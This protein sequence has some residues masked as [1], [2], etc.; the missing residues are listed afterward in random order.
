MKLE[1]LEAQINSN[2]ED[3][4]LWDEAEQAAIDGQEHEAMAALYAN[5][6]RQSIAP[7]AADE[8]GQRAVGWYE[9]WLGETAPGLAEVL[10]R[11]IHLDPENPWAFQKLTVI[12]TA[13]GRWE[14]LLAAYDS[15]IEVAASEARRREL[16]DE[17]YA[18]A[19]DLAHDAA[20]TS[21][22]LTKLLELDPKDENLAGSLERLLIKHD[23]HTGLVKHLRSRLPH[24]SKADGHATRLRMATTLYEKLGDADGAVGE[25]ETLFADGVQPEGSLELLEQIASNEQ[26][27]ESSR[28][29]AY[30][31]LE[32]RYRLAGRSDDLV[33][34]LNAALMLGGGEDPRLHRAAGEKMLEAGEAAG[35]FKHF[36]SVLESLPNDR[37]ARETLRKLVDETGDHDAYVDVLERA[38]TKAAE[39]D[40]DHQTQVSLLEEAAQVAYETNRD[41]ARRRTLLDSAFLVAQDDAQKLSVARE[42]ADTLGQLSEDEDEASIAQW[43]A[44]HGETPSER[45]RARVRSAQLFGKLERYDDAI[46]LWQSQLE[47]EPGDAESQRGLIEV[48]TRAERFEDLATYLRGRAQGEDTAQAQTDLERAAA[49]LSEQVGDA[50]QALTVWDEVERRFGASDRSVTARVELLERVERWEDAAGA[51][52]GEVERQSSALSRALIHAGR[53]KRDQLSRGVEAAQM[54]AR[55]LAFEPTN[56]PAREGLLALTE[57]EDAA[58]V[59][60]AGLA[61]AYRDAGE[62]HAVLNLLEPRLARAQSAQERTDLYREAFALRNEAGESEAA[63][64]DLIE[65]VRHSPDDEALSIQMLARARDNGLAEEAYAL[66]TELTSVVESDA[67][68]QNLHRMAFDLATRDLSRADAILHHGQIVFLEEPSSISVTEEVLRAA[69]SAEQWQLFGIVFANHLGTQPVL[70]GSFVSLVESLIGIDESPNVEAL[71]AIVDALEEQELAAAVARDLALTMGRWWIAADNVAQADA[72]YVRALEVDARS[73]E[74]IENLVSLRRPQGG[75]P[76]FEALGAA[77]A[78]DESNLDPGYEAA[79]IAL[80]L[81]DPARSVESLQ[82]VLDAASALVRQR[83]SARGERSAEGVCA[84]AIDTLAALCIREGDT[85][86]AL[87]VLESGSTM[88]MDERKRWMREAADLALKLGNRDRAT[89]LYRGV[90][91]IDED[92]EAMAALAALCEEDGRFVEM[93]GLR[94]RALAAAADLDERIRLRL[95]VARVVAEIEQRGGRIDALRDNLSEVPGHRESIEELTRVLESHGQWDALVDDLRVQARH[96]AQQGDVEFAATLWNKVA[97]VQQHHR[98]DTEAACDAFRNAVELV[99][100]P[101]SLEALA[102]LRTAQGEHA[103]AAQWLERR[104]SAAAEDERSEVIYKLAHAY[105][106]AGHRERAVLHL[107][108]GSELNPADRSI[109]DIL[110]ELYEEDNNRLGLAELWARSAVFLEK[111]DAM[112]AR[113]REAAETYSELGIPERAVSVLEQ[114]RTAA[115]DDQRIQLLYADALRGAERHEESI[116]VLTELAESFGRRRTPERADVH[117]RLGRVYREAG[118]LEEAIEQ[119]GKASSIDMKNPIYQMELGEVAVQ[120]RT[121]DK[122]ERAYRS[123]LLHVRRMDAP[124]KELG[125]GLADVQYEMSGLAEAQGDE[126][127]A[128]ELWRSALE[129]AQQR[130]DETATLIR[131]LIVSEQ[132]KRALEVAEA[133]LKEAENETQ[134]VELRGDIL[135]A[136]G[137]T[138]GALEAYCAA[139]VTSDM[140]NTELFDKARELASEHGQGELYL[141]SLESKF[142]KGGLTRAHK[143]TLLT[144]IARVQEEDLGRLED[145]TNTLRQI[146][147]LGVDPVAALQGQARIAARQGDT[148]TQGVILETIARGGSEIP[149]HHRADALL[150]LGEIKLNDEAERAQGTQFLEEALRLEPRYTDAAQ[151]LRKVEISMHPPAMDL[152]SQVVRSSTDSDL[153]L[154]F[155]AK[156]AR[157]RSATVDD[158]REAYA[159]AQRQ[160][161]AE[162]GREMLHRALEVAEENLD[163]TQGLWAAEA[164]SDELLEEGKPQEAFEILRKVA[165]AAGG[166]EGVRLWRKAAERAHQAGEVETAAEVYNSL[167]TA[168]PTHDEVWPSYLE[169]LAETNNEEAFASARQALKDEIFDGERRDFID[170]Q[171][172]KF[173]L[174]SDGRESEAATVLREILGNQPDHPEASSLLADVFERTGF[175]ED[176]VELLREQYDKAVAAQEADRIAEVG[177]RLGET[178]ARVD[179]EA[180][181]EVYRDASEKVPSDRALAEALLESLGDG[182]EVRERAIVEGRLLS[183]DEPE[184]VGTRALD[185]A[186][187]WEELGEPE[188]IVEVLEAAYERNPEQAK[189]REALEEAYHDASRWS[190]LASFL[191]REAARLDDPLE[192][193]ALLRRAATIRW[194]H[195][196]QA[197]AAAELLSR[198]I[199][200]SPEDPGGVE[201]AARMWFA[202]GKPQEVI[203]AVERSRP[204]VQD[205]DRWRLELLRA[206]ALQFD[207]RLDESVSAYRTAF[208]DAPTE[209]FESYQSA[210]QAL[211]QDARTEQDATRERRAIHEMVEVGRKLGQPDHAYD[212]LSEWHQSNMDDRESL[213]LLIE[214]DRET[215]NAQALISHSGLRVQMTEGEQQVEAALA[216]AEAAEQSQM[217]DQVVPVLESVAEEHPGDASIRQRL[218]SLYES[219]GAYSK[220]AGLLMADVENASDEDL[221]HELLKQAGRFYT[222]AGEAEAG[223]VP[224]QQAFEL[225][226]ED[227]ETVVALVDGYIGNN[228]IAEAGQTLEAAIAAHTRKRG[229]QLA[230][231][232]HRMARLAALAGDPDLQ[233]Q[234]LVVA[235][236]SD[237]SDLDIASELAELAIAQE[238]HDTALAALRTITL[239]KKAGPISRGRAFLMQAQVAHSKGENRRAI[240]WAR[241]ARS[242][243]PDLEEAEA[244][245]EQLN[246]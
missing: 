37:S 51:L 213:D 205:A 57:D 204:H 90:L 136:T 64:K 83:Q 221:R 223:L 89:E 226:P 52:E 233:I 131:R 26:M 29:H 12:H 22:Y 44:Q 186:V 104:L 3:P 229:P 179:L 210:L 102:E 27:K 168:H 216:L 94:R 209:V 86:R 77:F 122:A 241:K 239:S 63:A 141:K 173:L 110:V 55:A 39:L 135:L 224:L 70:S 111:R 20:A 181:A 113:A 124:A 95:E 40:D 172:A 80:G 154:D 244:F 198:A 162:I 79:Q 133:R 32:E 160:G 107:E 118:R 199:E 155:Q 75:L 34:T 23:D 176:L 231:L 128:S 185:L 200:L 182:A 156:K 188:R 60:L 236:E 161:N 41:I 153:L 49:L 76:A 54:L 137:D 36:A 25:L 194:Q 230:E 68:K 157:M 203:S 101:A 184:V 16:L 73:R 38:A 30:A 142:G 105:L 140:D 134:T 174:A 53:L 195:L 164:L 96:I 215:D 117:A 151:I 166:D 214:L 116:E 218:R 171:W 45:R 84:W 91:S 183:T 207:A 148:I 139:V 7:A 106:K 177:L 115:P 6:L 17:A 61:R 225:R 245:L 56:E 4:A 123:L 211:R 28:R 14:E 21:R 103:V 78:L 71:N 109:R 74:A 208:A 5:A 35:A 219:A 18:V 2:P 127:Q 62:R 144:R 15:M 121:F 93:L 178:L 8:I 175:S 24:Q 238:D 187:K 138:S 167:F 169:F 242:E 149:I 158:V 192:Q 120:N 100:S 201:D 43:L 108:R 130:P 147:E 33:R 126:A 145:A 235:M 99:P 243:E 220:L 197:D 206:Q 9:E 46:A 237:K 66:L 31:L 234:W 202:A 132:Y 81:D 50:E 189:V 125:F 58:D 87:R 10:E 228:Q 1:E 92:Q 152:Y 119:L 232:Q 85:D 165:D 222:L 97:T 114:A 82:R 212:L 72:C 112:V 48:L 191:G 150:A 193:A 65:A 246:A 227:H 11:V 67:R 69:A 129:R 59:A 196:E 19:R 170:L 240:L 180:A 88:P 159:L 47:A 98:N 163:I 217:A 190:P 42:L 143:S 13:E 146:E